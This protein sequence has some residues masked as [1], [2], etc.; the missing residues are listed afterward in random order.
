M[1]QVW[2]RGHF[3]HSTLE[4]MPQDSKLLWRQRLDCM[5][6]V[7]ATCVLILLQK[8]R[9]FRPDGIPEEAE[10]LPGLALFD[11]LSL[12]LENSWKEYSILVKNLKYKI[13]LHLAEYTISYPGI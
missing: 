6:G 9:A 10:W 8:A 3:K 13:K 1:A 4:D 12:Y 5:E 7:S 11:K 2:E